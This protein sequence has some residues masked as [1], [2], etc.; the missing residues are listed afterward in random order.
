MALPV[1][2]LKVM[3][4]YICQKHASTEFC[5][6][7]V[8]GTVMKYSRELILYTYF[9]WLNQG[10]GGIFLHV[11]GCTLSILLPNVMAVFSFDV[12]R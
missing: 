1:L 6:Q 5:T 3:V 8:N 10:T 12:A 2:W 7:Y 4:Y 9:Q 11:R